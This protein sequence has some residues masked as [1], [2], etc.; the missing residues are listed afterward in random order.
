MD[1]QLQRRPHRA[2]IGAQIDEVGEHEKQ[3][4]A[5]GQPRRIMPAQIAGDAEA[6]DAADARADLL[7]RHHQRVAEHQRPGQAIA[8]LGADLRIGGD[9]AGVIIRGAG[10]QARPQHLEKP[11]AIGLLYP[12][13]QGRS[14][15]ALRKRRAGRQ[16]PASARQGKI[17]ERDGPLGVPVAQGATRLA[18]TSNEPAVARLVGL[19]RCHRAIERP[20]LRHLQRLL[21]LAGA[22]GNERDKRR[23]QV[24][25]RRCICAG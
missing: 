15:Q 1:Q 2:Q 12:I 11:W 7:D 10:D 8:E 13:A 5:A 24:L 9:A 6:G 21:R 3:H 25:M 17:D 18:N 20:R 4:D 23:I 14:G 16:V 22:A 19:V